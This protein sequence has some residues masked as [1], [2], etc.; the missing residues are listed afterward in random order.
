MAGTEKNDLPDT[1]VCFRELCFAIRPAADIR[2]KDQRRLGCLH[3]YHA[4]CV[5]GC[6]AIS[7]WKMLRPAKL[8]VA[9]TARDGRALKIKQTFTDRH[10]VIGT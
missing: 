10:A 9:V 6:S 8:H 7:R 3:K 1:L 4:L 5:C 2:C